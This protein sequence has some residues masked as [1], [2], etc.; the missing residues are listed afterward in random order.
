MN[1]IL[2]FDAGP[3]GVRLGLAS[4]M[5]VMKGILDG[6]MVIAGSPPLFFFERGCSS[7]QAFDMR[8]PAVSR[9]G[10][11]PRSRHLE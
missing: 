9:F 3:C 2:S 7:H 4:S 5:A 10:S 1:P 6:L 8:V 11:R